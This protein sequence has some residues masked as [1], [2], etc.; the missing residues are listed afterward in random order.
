MLQ[1][2]A[3]LTFVVSFLDDGAAAA[4]ACAAIADI[5]ANVM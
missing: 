5:D 4:A 3:C 1:S 2:A